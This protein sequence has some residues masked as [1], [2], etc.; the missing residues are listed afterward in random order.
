MMSNP[1]NNPR[2]ISKLHYSPYRIHIHFAT[3]SINLTNYII[4]KYLVTLSIC[5]LYILIRVH[6]GVWIIMLFDILNHLDF[7]ITL[8]VSDIVLLLET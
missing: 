1:Q 4:H 2:I 7:N 8:G 3:L 5:L 6:D